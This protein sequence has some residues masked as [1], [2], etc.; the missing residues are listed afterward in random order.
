MSAHGLIVVKEITRTHIAQYGWES[1]AK[2]NLNHFSLLDK[3]LTVTIAKIA[4]NT[5]TK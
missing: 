4:L 5:A 3:N 1:E 2:V